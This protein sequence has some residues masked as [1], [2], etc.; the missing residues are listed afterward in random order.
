MEVNELAL[1]IISDLEDELEEGSQ[2]HPNLIL[3]DELEEGLDDPKSE[4]VDV[5]AVDSV[6][7]VEDPLSRLCLRSQQHRFPSSLVPR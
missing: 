2:N 4:V 6:A 5:G 3:G 1:I 7:A